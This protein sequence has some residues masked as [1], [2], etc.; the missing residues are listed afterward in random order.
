MVVEDDDQLRSLTTAVLSADGLDVVASVESHEEAMRSAAGVDIGVVDLRLRGKSG[1]EVT[2][3]L[4]GRGVKVLIFTGAEDRESLRA[5][6]HAGA[7][8]AVLKGGPVDELPRAV[9]A[10]AGGSPYVTSRLHD[11][12]APAKD[13]TLS[14]REREV[15][16]LLATGHGN[17]AIAEELGLSPQTVKTQLKVAMR[18]LGART[19]VEAV[20]LASAAGEI[21]LP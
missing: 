8:G 16:F 13:G 10:V 12:M 20:A 2:R 4:T 19:R 11:L 15:L 18:K 21:T 9:R 6:L 7:F 17:D 3:E 1:I 5:A 14:P